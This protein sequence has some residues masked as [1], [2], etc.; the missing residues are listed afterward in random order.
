MCRSRCGFIS[1]VEKGRF[2][3]V[4]PDPTHPTGHALCAKNQAGPEQVYSPDRLLYPMRRT[5]PKGAIDPGWERISWAEAL[6]ETAR[7]LRRFAKE[8]GPH[9]AAFAITTP[10][11]TSM[12][13]S[14]QWVERLMRA[15]GSPNNCYGTEICNWH[16]DIA[17]QFTFSTSIG[18]LDFERTECVLL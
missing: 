9:S 6:D 14:I 15:Y 12:S 13:D 5:N 3:A 17:T 4:G 10:S 8:D 7:A 16:K 18:N 11:G 2:I 1:V